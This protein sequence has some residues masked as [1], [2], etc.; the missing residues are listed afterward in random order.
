MSI[1]RSKKRA[2]L[3]QFI[4]KKFRQVLSIVA[5]AFNDVNENLN[6]YLYNIINFVCFRIINI[7][8]YSQIK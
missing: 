1:K 2:K 5:I 7:V 6:N 3:R 8:I 4:D